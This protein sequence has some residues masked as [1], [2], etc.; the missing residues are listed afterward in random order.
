VDPAVLVDTELPGNGGQ[1]VQYDRVAIL[2]KLLA[3][4]EQQHARRFRTSA[5]PGSHM[6][7]LQ[8]PDVDSLARDARQFWA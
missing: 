7:L 2:I 1:P 5:I 3:V 8:R 4:L 6:T